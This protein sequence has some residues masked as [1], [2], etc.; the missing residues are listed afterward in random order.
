V[1]DNRIVERNVNVPI[2]RIV[3]CTRWRWKRQED[4]DDDD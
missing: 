1:R 2:H 3:D 4:D